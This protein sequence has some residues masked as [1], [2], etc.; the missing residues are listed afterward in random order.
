M[1]ENTTPIQSDDPIG[2]TPEE[3][4]NHPR[5]APY[6]YTRSKIA[7]ADVSLDDSVPL[8]LSAHETQSPENW[9]AAEQ[10]K[11]TGR[12]RIVTGV[13]AAAALAIALALVPAGA[14]RT[15]IVNAQSSLPGA[16]PAQS[17]RSPLDP[18]Q[19][20][21]RTAERT[22]TA[23]KPPLQVHAADSAQAPSSIAATPTREEIAAAYQAAMQSR[24]TPPRIPTPAR[25]L[26]PD[27]LASL[28][29]R[30][31]SLLAVA[32]IASARLL[33]ER[34]ADAQEAGAALM[35][36][37]TYDPAVLGTADARSVTPDLAQARIWYRKAAE[38][39]SRDAQLR[40]AQMQN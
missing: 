8:F 26:D 4:I 18:A 38:L 12:L 7:K 25:R 33:L 16:S 36:A 5:F 14:M 2:E 19:L 29:K 30:A 28:L 6:R 39:G 22:G 21:T 35:L 20:S 13:L 10:R 31:K 3:D 32:D 15:V 24:T 40:L 9:F 34:A 1:A 23:A 27:E 37:R 11:A 17:G